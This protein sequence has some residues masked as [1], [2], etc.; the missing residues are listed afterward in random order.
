MFVINVDI[1]N[2]IE[3]PFVRIAVVQTPLGRLLKKTGKNSIYTK[4][5]KNAQLKFGFSSY[6]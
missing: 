6:F 3:N 1:F 5:L 4:K 2:G